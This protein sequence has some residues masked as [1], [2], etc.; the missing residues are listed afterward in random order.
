MYSVLPVYGKESLKSSG[1][2]NAKPSLRRAEPALHEIARRTVENMIDPKITMYANL[3]HFQKRAGYEKGYLLPSRGR[4]GYLLFLPKQPI[5]WIDEQLNQTWRIGMRVSSPIY[6]KTSVFVASLEVSDSYLS[7]EDCWILKGETLYT[8]Q[9]FSKRWQTVLDFYSDSY[10][11]DSMLQRGLEIVCANYS[12]LSAFSTLVAGDIQWIHWVPEDPTK[13]RLRIQ[14]V[15]PTEVY[16]HA[17]QTQ[18]KQQ[19]QQHRINSNKP[20]FTQSSLPSAESNS[21]KHGPKPCFTQNAPQRVQTPRGPQGD[22][23][24]ILIARAVVNPLFPDAYSLLTSD[25]VEKGRAAVQQFSLS[26]ALRS[27]TEKKGGACFV[28]VR[29]NVDFRCYQIVS[30]APPSTTEASHGT[31]FTEAHATER[32]QNARM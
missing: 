17:Q 26:Q 27:E 21:L 19:P 28:V 31:K 4:V 32:P 11:Y 29:W 2:G 23:T 15:A 16:Q 13:K 7:L 1:L 3:F 20:P 25:G 6:E 12:P 9:P 8:Q 14:L 18:Q 5:V 22:D 24:G 30:I 10:R